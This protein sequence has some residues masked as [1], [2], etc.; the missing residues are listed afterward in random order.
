MQ[1][2][3]RTQQI[4]INDYGIISKNK[5]KTARSRKQKMINTHTRLEV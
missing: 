5:V 2:V 4:N 1:Y 3:R